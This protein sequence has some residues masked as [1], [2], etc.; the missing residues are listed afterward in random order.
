MH[1]QMLCHVLHADQS[2]R[3]CTSQAYTKATIQA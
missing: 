3:V 2:E 1:K